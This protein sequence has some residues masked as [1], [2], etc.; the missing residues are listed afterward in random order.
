MP[1]QMIA[2][3]TIK[4]IHIDIFFMCCRDGSTGRPCIIYTKEIDAPCS[5]PYQPKFT[6]YLFYGFHHRLNGSIDTIIIHLIE[7]TRNGNRR[8]TVCLKDRDRNTT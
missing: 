4:T 3:R 8:S 2:I 1:D 6:L 5:H 7:L